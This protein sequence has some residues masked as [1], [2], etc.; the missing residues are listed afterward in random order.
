MH[1]T[2]DNKPVSIFEVKTVKS[3][4]INWKWTWALENN[5]SISTHW[6][7]RKKRTP[8]LFNGKVFLSQSPQILENSCYFPIFETDY[9]NLLYFLDI[10]PK[11]FSIWNIF[12]TGALLGNDNNFICC[13]MAQHTANPGKIYFP[14]GTPDYEDCLNGTDIDLHFSLLREL[15]EET[16]LSSGFKVSDNWTI[17]KHWPYLA[18]FKLIEFPEPSDNIV[19]KINNNLLLQNNSELTNACIITPKTDIN[20]KEFPLYL[21]RFLH[22]YF[23]KLL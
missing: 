17:V 16:G 9:A 19:K 12:A 18:L 7:Y 14:A 13:R 6:N 15:Q 20:K 21:Q 2:M 11:E 4:L 23:N 10:R 3:P 8:A 5:K 22:Y 1:S